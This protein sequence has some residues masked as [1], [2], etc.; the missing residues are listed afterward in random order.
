[1]R[2]L[3]PACNQALHGT[4]VLG[5]CKVCAPVVEADD[6]SEKY[7]EY[8]ASTSMFGHPSDGEK[9]KK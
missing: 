8:R 1:M 9:K 5:S 4:R 3:C 2:V 6:W 7:H